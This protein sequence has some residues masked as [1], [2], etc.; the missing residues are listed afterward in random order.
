M[1]RTG[2][3][4]PALLNE[5]AVCGLSPDASMLE[6]RAEQSSRI[7]SGSGGGNADSGT[8]GQ[9]SERPL[10]CA[11]VDWGLREVRA[12]RCMCV[13]SLTE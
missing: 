4:C 7:Q 1:R 6:S 13:L 3:L 10:L 2:W 12:H 5:T 9:L 8:R 11:S